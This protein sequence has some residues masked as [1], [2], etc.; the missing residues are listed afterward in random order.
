VPLDGREGEVQFFGDPAI[1][2]P[3]TYNWE[4]DTTRPALTWTEKPG[5]TVDS[6]DWYTNDNTPTWAYA[7]SDKNLLE[8]DPQCQLDSETLDKRIITYQPCPSPTTFPF[9]LADGEYSFYVYH[10]DKADNGGYG[11]QSLTIDT[12]APAAP[13]ISSPANNSSDADSS[14]AFSGTTEPD[15]TVEIY[16]GATLKGTVTADWNGQWSKTLAGV[17]SGSHTYTAKAI[18]LAGNTSASSSAVTVTV[19]TTSTAPSNPKVVGT[20][21][22]GG[23][24]GVLPGATVT[25]AFSEAMMASTINRTNVKLVKK[26]TTTVIGVT[27]SYDSAAKKA[28]LNPSSNLVRG[29]T[30]NATVTTGAKDLAGYG[31]DQN[32]SLTGLQPKTWSFT[33]RR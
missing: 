11:Y 32:S 15:A 26:G 2:T 24:T 28:T 30:Y 10:Y 20:S 9:E 25:A 14:I 16:E 21:P 18:D 19:G 7:Y 23:A 8:G 5:T 29:A 12:A 27:V 17:A 22:L 31:L 33:V 13:V 4:V 6:Y 3:A 1:L